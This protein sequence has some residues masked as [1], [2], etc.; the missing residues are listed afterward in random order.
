[1]Q[2]YLRREIN[3]K[4]SKIKWLNFLETSRATGKDLSIRYRCLYKF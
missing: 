1:M 4:A 2:R 3:L